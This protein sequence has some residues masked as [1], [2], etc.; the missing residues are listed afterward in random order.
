MCANDKT[1]EYEETYIKPKKRRRI[2]LKEEKE[3]LT[4]IASG[5][6][7]AAEHFLEIHFPSIERLAKKYASN[8]VPVDDLIQEGYLGYVEALKKYHLSNKTCFSAYAYKHIERFIQYASRTYKTRA[9]VASLDT[10]KDESGDIKKEYLLNCF[11]SDL[12]DTVIQHEMQR[13]VQNLVDTSSLSESQKELLNLYYREGYSSREIGEMLKISATSVYD[14]MSQSLQQLLFDMKGAN[15]FKE[16]LD[17]PTNTY[18]ISK[19][20]V[21]LQKRK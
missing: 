4:K 3:E 7:Q 6:K 15:E 9:D 12:D 8:E 10:I 1:N 19:R 14:N 20:D 18:D 17:I 16:Y 2:F 11:H 21:V 13:K 5:D